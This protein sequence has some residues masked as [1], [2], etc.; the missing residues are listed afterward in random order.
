MNNIKRIE[1]EAKKAAEIIVLAAK[2][3]SNEDKVIDWESRIQNAL[4]NFAL[5]ILE[6]NNSGHK[7]G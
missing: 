5:A 2:L 6:I 3:A 7:L 4:V 1:D